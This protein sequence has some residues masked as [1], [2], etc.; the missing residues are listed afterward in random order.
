[1]I[2][3]IGSAAGL[4]VK[5]PLALLP[6]F[7]ASLA[8]VL[9]SVFFQLRLLELFSEF[10]NYSLEA[11]DLNA[12]VFFFTKQAASI[13][14]MLGLA[15][16]NSFLVLL[17]GVYYCRYAIT[18]QRKGSIGNALGFALKSSGNIIALLITMAIFLLAAI[19]AGFFF[20]MLPLYN[21][22]L[23]TTII[24]VYCIIV[25]IFAMRLF[26]FALPAL[27]KEES[28]AKKAIKE[29][30]AFTKKHF[31]QS[32]LLALII[33]FFIFAISAIA[34]LFL[35]KIDETLA[36]FSLRSVF[37]TILIAFCL[38]VLAIYYSKHAE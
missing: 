17:F 27:A 14:Y 31:W 28:N 5:R 36:V 16:A 30:W 33:I 26:M 2:N 29:S 7:F 24:A 25:F 4:M 13:S 38:G 22:F 35:E 32:L 8:C 37:D 19:S 10:I 15:L 11:Q 20:I 34:M 1:M 9:I 18:V 12:A 3:A 6:I 21:T 23:Y